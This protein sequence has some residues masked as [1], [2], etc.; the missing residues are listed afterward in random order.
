CNYQDGVLAVQLGQAL[1]NIDEVRTILTEIG[2][3]QLDEHWSPVQIL[4]EQNS[5]RTLKYAGWDAKTRQVAWRNAAG[6]T[7]S[8]GLDEGRVKL[9]WRLD[10]PARWAKWGVAVEPFGRD[11]A[12][13]GGSYDTGVALVERVFGGRPPLPVPYEFINAAGQT[14]KISKSS[15]DSLTPSDVLQVMPPEVLR[16]FVIHPRPG[17]TLTF[18]TGIG[19]Y[20]LMEEFTAALEQ[21]TSL[22]LEY[23]RAVSGAGEV[24]ARVPFAHL[25]AVYQAARGDAEQV[26]VLLERTDYEEV[27]AQQWPVIERELKFV[28][29]W[30]E[31][32]A[33]DNVKFEVQDTLPK[34]ELSPGQKTFLAKLAKVVADEKDL[35]GQGMH[36]AVYASTE[37]AGIKAADGFRAV[38]RALLGKDFGPKAG[39]FLASLERDWLVKRLQDAA[40]RAG[41]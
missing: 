21:P 17:R 33:P 4:D 28:A 10:W 12:T 14:K 19:L 11:H 2:G 23:A 5:L 15:G 20:Q 16:Y 32:Y 41:N 26:R 38:Y 30:L 3:R 27:A 37:A 8:V 1:D 6:E 31:K 35:N 25:V 34:V 9:D 18:D 40:G 22:A 7:G 24:V 39:W 13:K 29:N 36:D